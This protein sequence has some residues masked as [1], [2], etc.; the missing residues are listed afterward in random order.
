M[1]LLNEYLE[2][3]SKTMLNMTEC[4]RF[5]PGIF[6]I[7]CSSL[8]VILDKEA[9]H[10]SEMSQI[11]VYLMGNHCNC[12]RASVS[13]FDGE[14]TATNCFKASVSV[15]DGETT[16]TNCFKAS[17]SIFDGETISTDCFKASV[18][19]F[20]GE[21][22]SAYCFKASVSLFDRETTATN[23]FKA[24]VSLFSGKPLQLIVQGTGKFI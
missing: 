11:T 10:S 23:C 7:N 14:T 19:L 21:T 17:V 8:S 12:F 1:L 9:V 3:I 15:F 2:T 22:T 4:I 16:A 5:S 6:L 18:S 24:S 13:L 20:D